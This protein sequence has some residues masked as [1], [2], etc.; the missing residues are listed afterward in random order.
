MKRYNLNVLL[1]INIIKYINIINIKCVWVWPT[2]KRCP[3]TQGPSGQG[4]TVL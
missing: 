1:F 4:S 2:L 3:V